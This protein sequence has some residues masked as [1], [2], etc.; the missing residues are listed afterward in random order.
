M[1]ALVEDLL[2]LA[3]L[4]SGRPLVSEPVDLTRLLVEAVSDSRVL[5]PD[6]Q[7]RL[8]L[9][10]ESVEVTGDEHRLHQVV[11]NLLANARKYTPAGTTVTVSAHSG[12]FAV[13]DD[14]PGFPDDLVD[15]AFERF[16]RGDVARTRAGKGGGYGLGLSLVSAIVT[17]HGGRVALRSV[18]GDTTVS[19]ELP[20]AP[21]G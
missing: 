17:A 16:A 12:G 8:S 2:L 10:E 11:T 5:A 15:H 1:T 18:P 14:G 13:H 3:R 4:D 9:P 7:W 20:P 6:H 21:A 19:V